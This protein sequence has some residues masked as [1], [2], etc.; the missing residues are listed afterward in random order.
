MANVVAALINNVKF[1]K[2]VGYDKQQKQ[3]V[4]TLAVDIVTDTAF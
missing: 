3:A 2:R 1:H 4:Q